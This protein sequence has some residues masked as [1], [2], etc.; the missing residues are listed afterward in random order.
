MFNMATKIINLADADT[1]KYIR[2]TMV[3]EFA[4]DNPEYLKLSGEEQKTYISEFE[5]KIAKV[6]PIM[7]DV[8]ITTLST[9]KFEDLYTAEGKETLRKEL[10]TAISDRVKEFTL[11][12]VYF[13]EFVVQ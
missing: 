1:R 7:D 4:P 5:A 3:M 6:M 11:I 12:S 8:V 10:I 9:K 13:T 2:L